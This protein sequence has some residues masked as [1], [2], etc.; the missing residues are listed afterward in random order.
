M[1]HLEEK[2]EWTG[3]KELKGLFNANGLT[4]I[5]VFRVKHWVIGIG[6][7]VKKA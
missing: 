5:K 2:S 3:I 1:E 6:R 4:I 7:K